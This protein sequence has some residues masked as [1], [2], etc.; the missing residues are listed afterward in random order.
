MT[1]PYNLSFTNSTNPV[2]L[3][4]GVNTAAGGAIG[5]AICLLIYFIVIKG[6]MDSGNGI[7]TSLLVSSF[8]NG[9][10]CG[11]LWGLTLLPGWLLGVNI[12]IFAAAIF[13]KIFG[14]KQ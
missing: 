4:S 9:I 3:L 12:A 2:S 13:I 7:G 11:L 6:S 8:I 5:A 1:V 14:E 10:I